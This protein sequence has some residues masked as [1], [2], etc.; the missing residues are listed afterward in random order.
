MT[1]SV[2]PTGFDAVIPVEQV[3]I[4]DEDGKFFL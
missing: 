1:G 3:E 4:T 2:M